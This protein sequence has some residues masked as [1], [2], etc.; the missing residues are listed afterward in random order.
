MKKTLLIA[1][2]MAAAALLNGCVII[3][4]NEQGTVRRPLVIGGPS[5]RVGVIFLPRDAGSDSNRPHLRTKPRPASVLTSCLAEKSDYN[6]S[7]SDS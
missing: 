5:H 1:G 4:A 7:R 2:L 3:S 6:D